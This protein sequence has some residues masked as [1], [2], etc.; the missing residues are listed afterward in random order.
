MRRQSTIAALPLVPALLN[1]DHR[2]LVE[3]FLVVGYFFADLYQSA[4]GG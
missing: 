2:V 3:V 4:L 1:R